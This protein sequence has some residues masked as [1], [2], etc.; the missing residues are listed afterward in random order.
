MNMTNVGSIQR[1]RRYVFVVNGVWLYEAREEL[2][3]FVGCSVQ[4]FQDAFGL[5]CPCT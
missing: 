3:C 1:R 4:F 2:L 5:R